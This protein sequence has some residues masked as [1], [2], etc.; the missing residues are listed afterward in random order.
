ML[1]EIELRALSKDACK[2]VKSISGHDCIDAITVDT[3]LN[4]YTQIV[5]PIA[6]SINL[7][8]SREAAKNIGIQIIGG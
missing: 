8:L 3:R 1:I 4:Q 5:N 7:I 6:K 2:K